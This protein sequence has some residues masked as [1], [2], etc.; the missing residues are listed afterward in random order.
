ME[1]TYIDM[2]STHYWFDT[3]NPNQILQ[4]KCNELDVKLYI[5]P[6]IIYKNAF[7]IYTH[8]SQRNM[9]PRE[10]PPYN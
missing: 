4:H 8:I 6:C 2:N 3:F 1:N 10:K 9:L 5:S 7:F